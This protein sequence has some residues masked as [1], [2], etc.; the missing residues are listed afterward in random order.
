MSN[1]TPLQG[2]AAAVASPRYSAYSPP[3]IAPGVAVALAAVVAAPPVKEKVVVAGLQAVARASSVLASKPPGRYRIANLFDGKL[4]TAW[5]EGA[6]GD[7]K[8]EWVEVAFARPVALDG[9]FLAPGYGLTP[10]IFQDNRVPAL[11]ELLADGKAV[12]GYELR[13]SMAI[14]SLG[15]FPAAATWNWAPRVVVFDGPVVAKRL[16]LIV[17]EVLPSARARFD[18]LALSEW[19]PWVAGT[20]PA[21]PGS[22]AWRSALVL[23]AETLRGARGDSTWRGWAAGAVVADVF[24]PP[25]SPRAAAFWDLIRANLISSGA[26]PAGDRLASFTAFARSGLWD[27]AVTLM[28]VDEDY[29]AVGQRTMAYGS[30]E[31]VNLFPVLRLSSGGTAARLVGLERMVQ[32]GLCGDHALPEPSQE[33]R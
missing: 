8:G 7:G 11:L 23:A 25:R 27:A 32:P 1:V 17:K 24:E 12:N 16:R 26:R 33:L 30:P 5:V 18:D 2:T 13:Y 19:T 4:E 6:K 28:P 21:I 31:R 22:E 20:R 15:C 3:V 9:F 10:E 29:L 14:V